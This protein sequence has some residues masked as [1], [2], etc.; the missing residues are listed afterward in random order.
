MFKSKLLTILCLCFVVQISCQDSVDENS[1]RRFIASQGYKHDLLILGG[2][3]IDGMGTEA[4]P[5][6]LII[7]HD[8]IAFIG[9]VDTNLIEVD[10]LIG[11][12]GLTVCPG[13]ID[14]HAH[15]NPMED[16]A[17]ENFLAMG[18]TT[19][20]LGQDG[21]SPVHDN[22]FD[23][24]EQYFDALKQRDLG[25]NLAFL[26]GHGSLRSSAGIG[27]KSNLGPEEITK[28]KQM[29]GQSLE[30]GCFGMSTGL[31][32]V[33]GMNATTVELDALAQTVGEFD[34]LIMSHMRSEDDDQ[35]VRSIAELAA[36]GTYCRTHISHLKVVYGKGRERGRQIIDLVKSYE[37]K[38]VKITA[39]VYPYLAGYTGISI[40]F[41]SWAKTPS[42]FEL[43]KKTR[44]IEF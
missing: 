40:V 22:Q 32:Y 8:T 13:F 6:D 14:P 11:A 42:A 30:A 3:V 41:P 10:E 20:V 12:R 35:I 17:F 31:E 33:P 4:F 23:G 26:A 29:L 28:L 7:N 21:S 24:A 36:Q 34:G 37:S 18:V 16:A 19:I 25:V 2:S 43:A 9:D 39:D 27:S 1:F 38:G 44:D 15:G 5:A